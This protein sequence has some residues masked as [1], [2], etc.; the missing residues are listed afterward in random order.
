MHQPDQDRHLNQRPDNSGKR[1][2]GVDPEYRY[3]YGD[4][5]LE[6]VARSRERDG[7]GLGVSRTDSFAHP[8]RHQEH[9]HE[10]NAQRNRDSNDV[11]R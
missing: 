2:A 11:H 6:I 9:D 10:V 7:R 8:K 3:G 5:K 1:H 4:R